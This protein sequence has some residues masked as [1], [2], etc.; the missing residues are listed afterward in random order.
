[1]TEPAE[2]RY[3]KAADGAHLAYQIVGDGP[4]DVLELPGTLMSID[5]VGDQPIWLRFQERLASF[6]RLIR[7]DLR[8][9]GLSDPLDASTPP[10]VERWMDDALAV[11]DAA[12]S[13]RTALWGVGFGGTIALLLAAS[14]PDRVSALILINAFARLVRA[15]DYEPGVPAALL[16]D[17]QESLVDPAQEPLADD[18]DLIAPSLADDPEFRAWWRR[19]GNRGASPATAGAVYRTLMAADLRH[20]LPDIQAPTLVIHRAGN[21]FVR[22]GQGRWLAAHLPAARYVELPGADHVAWLD[23]SD[24]IADESEEFLTGVRR[25]PQATRVLATVL[26]SDI[27][28]STQRAAAIGDGEWRHVLDR[29]DDMVRRLLHRFAGR[30]VKATG[31]GFM[32][33]F[34]GPARAIQCAVAIRD[35]ARQLGL[36]VRV[37]LHCGEVE[38]RGAD[39]GGIAVHI[40]QRVESLADPGEVLVSRTVKDLVAGSTI[41][42]DDRGE[43][44]LKGV[45]DA[46]QLFGVTR[47]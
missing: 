23:D 5:A 30:E 17:F 20:T 8:G 25:A 19:S 34:D 46:W 10:T 44:V 22:V 9:I 28:S 32:A 41:A 40:A 39:I 12:G 45:P 29:H 4:I 33:T 43:H 42:F 14:H 37:G 36:D 24:A 6:C 31:D 1:M 15:P 7:I 35:G 3:A 47:A 2:T 11:L 38:L 18:V 27:A 16:V 13:E 21:N 26:F